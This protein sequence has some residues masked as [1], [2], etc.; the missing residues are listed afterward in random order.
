CRRPM[1][2]LSVTLGSGWVC[3][4]VVSQTVAERMAKAVIDR[5]PSVDLDARDPDY[6]RDVLPGAWLL[7]TLWHRAEVRG[8]DRVPETGPVLLV[9]NHSGGNVAPDTLVF[10]LAFV[11]WFGVERPFF[12]L[13]HDLVLRMPQL[14]W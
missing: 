7:A 10:T 4:S 11:S 6:I 13:A 8:L 9:G 14:R 1:P 3:N 2:A 5:V 12:Q